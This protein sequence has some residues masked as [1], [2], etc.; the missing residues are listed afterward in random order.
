ML[1]YLGTHEPSWLGRAGVP[2]FVSRRR[3]ARLR[4][5]LPVAVER[6]ALD[7]GGFTEL[8]MHGRWL[9]SP[10]QYAR[11][12]RL[13]MDKVGR[14]DWA[15]AQDWMCE[16]WIL[17]KTGLSVREHQQRTVDNYL[18]LCRLA[19]ELPWVPVLQGWQYGDYLRHIEDYARA[20]VNLA[21]LDRVGLGSVCRRQD[22]GMVEDLLGDLAGLGIRA[23][24]FGFK[25]Q[26]LRRAAGHLA[27]ADSLAWS[28]DARR[29]APLPGHP[30]RSCANCLEY[31]LGWRERVLC[32]IGNWQPGLFGRMG[33]TRR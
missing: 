8:S 6:W 26:G 22:T 1:F 3:L 33:L 27:S 12:V 7:S 21:A 23:H 19:P 24:G 18:D 20:G 5:K 16:P 29:A 17:G 9:T 2:L 4:R 25:L 13:W 11:E 10:E 14:L 31:A 15:A 32:R 30:H 28:Y